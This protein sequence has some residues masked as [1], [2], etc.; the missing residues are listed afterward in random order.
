MATVLDFEEPIAELENKVEQLQEFSRTHDVDV[1]SGVELLQQRIEQTKR[2]IFDELT[3]MQR[4]R[5]ARHPDR[6]YPQD[7]VQRI[8]TDFLELHGDRRYADDGAIFGGFAKL[9]DQR[10]MV[11]GTRKGRNLKDNV[12]CNFGCAHPEGYRKALRLMRIADKAGVPVVSL[13]DTPGAY[14][15]VEAEE[16]H[17]AE[18]I[19]LNLREM[20]RLNV[21]IV[22]TVVGE[23]GSG[24]A[25]G[26]GVGDK[27]LIMQHAYYS[28]IT[29]EGCAAILWRD[30]KKA[31][32]AAEA[33]KLTS[34][35][36]KE[37]GLVHQIVPEPLGGAHRQPEEAA[38]NLKEYLK[39]SLDDLSGKDISELRQNRYKQF[40]HVGAFQTAENTA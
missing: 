14:P 8:F 38:E 1:T 26:I 34:S 16:R 33:L 28:V 5:L 12:W 21:P 37:R 23:G 22:V 17:I 13:I 40:R 35:A 27:L 32:N 36:L 39:N 7:Y 29:P 30:S 20:F 9:D 11:I 6:P 19:A 4:V 18:S 24:G 10:V 2:K 3:P 31:E 25:L 15:G